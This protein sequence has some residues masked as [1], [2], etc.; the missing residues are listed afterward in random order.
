MSQAYYFVY[1]K[2]KDDEL[3]QRVIK[4]DNILDATAEFNA[5]I[6]GDIDSLHH[7]SI[8]NSPLDTKS[9]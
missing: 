2:S 8:R 6:K 4:A 9:S 3:E 7:L 1:Q 5:S